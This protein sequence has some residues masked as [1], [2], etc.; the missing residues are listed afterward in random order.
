M[1]PSVQLFL[2]RM[3]F[4]AFSAFY[5]S[6]CAL[7]VP[8]PPAQHMPPPASAE[9]RQLAAA[10]SLLHQGRLPEAKASVVDF[11]QSHASC[12]EGYNLLGIVCSTEGDYDC[13]LAAF[14]HALK[15][16]ARSTKTYT[17]LGNF[18]ASQAKYDLAEGEFRRALALA[19]S[20]PEANYGLG[21]LLLSEGKPSEAVRALQ[22]VHPAS[23]EAQMNLVRAYLRSSRTAEGLRLATQLSAKG[24]S[25]VQRH[26]TLGLLLAEE[27]QYR[28]AKLEL[29]KAD[30]LKPLT[31]EILYNLGLVD[32]R[33][34]DYANAQ[35]VLRRALKLRP[36]SAETMY[37]L[38]QVLDEESRPLDAL[39]LL[40]QA[41]KIAPGNADIIFLLA[42]ITMMQAF[43]ADAIPLLESGV[44][45]A[46]QRADLHAALG[47]SYFASG[48]TE[49]A[50]E[51][52]SQLIALDPSALSY[53]FMGLSYRHLGRFDDARKYFEE[54]LKRDPT[55]S[56][57]W[58]NLGFIDER[59]GNTAAA[60]EKFQKALRSNPNFADALFELADLRIKDK[61]FT[62]GTNL[63][64]RYVKVSRDPAAGYYKLAMIERSR[65]EIEAADRDLKVFQTLS[66]DSP[67]G[68]Y[69]YQ[70][71]FDYLDNRSALS[72]QQRTQL[73]VTQLTA[74]LK[75]EPDQPQ[76]LY[77][78]AEAYLKLD[79][80]REALQA[81]SQFDQV[82]A[83]D[84]HAQTGIGVLLA[85]YRLYDRAISHFQNALRLYS[86][87]DE[88]RF[89]L[90]DAYF[91]KG[92]YSEA[93]QSV[94]TISA[95]GQKDDA[96]L[97]L[98]G[99]IYA[100]LGESAK[101]IDIYRDAIARNPDND[102][103]YLSLMLVQLRGGDLQSAGE[104]LKKGLN[105]I[106]ASGKLQWGLGL[107]SALQGNTAQA[108]EQ[109]ER[110][111]D[112]LPEWAGSYSTLGVFYYQTGQI[113]KAREV[114]DR[115]KGSNTGG[116]DVQR[117][118][119]VLSQAPT[120]SASPNAP[121]SMEA[122]QQLLR[123]ALVI[124][125]RTL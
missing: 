54:A 35:L 11:L 120:T 4:L 46:P 87:S 74:Q 34:R 111:V 10:A 5:C 86:D 82:S 91:R 76:S 102:Q 42:R 32:L 67:T 103:Y 26:F 72:A 49:K 109:L 3:A 14:E 81:I 124:A 95:N 17:N 20:D 27:K 66:T 98:L 121:L 19:P 117:I 36:D 90:A 6:I 22:R 101:S 84:Y 9:Q 77:L 75:K 39:D 23:V 89:D 106:P 13:A 79:K 70:H 25:E 119:Q 71:F 1:S 64:R 115:F 94:Q 28:A 62:E 24:S 52:F 58:F 38:G 47:E 116:L 37:L 56:A 85:Q 53:I 16:N 7:A 83:D 43:Y 110:A 69:P 31:F 80:R 61:R 15:L 118:E 12:V 113:E 50:I 93:L 48:K 41:H 107:I 44:K 21:L 30:A 104:T 99:D 100:H 108:A 57:C 33:S 92:M 8:L 2:K 105:R 55:N 96:C 97:S 123:F 18:Y 63:L 60:D 68:P 78:L 73:D 59:Q 29:E 114:L 40:T 112:L 125:D 65:H 45:I 51:E 122:K 88:I